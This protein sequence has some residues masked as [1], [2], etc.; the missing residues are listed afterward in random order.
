MAAALP[1]VKWCAATRRGP[2]GASVRDPRRVR[3]GSVRDS[4]KAAWG[5]GR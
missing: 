1:L 4:R 2:S 5:R 3:R